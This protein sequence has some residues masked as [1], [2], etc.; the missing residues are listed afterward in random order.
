MVL[1]S[2]AYVLND[3]AVRFAS[4]DGLGVYQVVCL[5]GAMMAA[6]FAGVAMIRG[7]SLTLS[8]IERPVL[9]RVFAE[10]VSTMLFFTALVRMEFA[11]AQAIL[12]ILPLA[13]I[14]A[15]AFV[16][17]EAVSLRRY[18]AVFAGFVGVLIVVRPATDGFTI[19]SIAVLASVASMIVRELA[20]RRVSDA[21]PAL[22]IAFLT[23]VG[24]TVLGGLLATSEGWDSVT[25]RSA[26][27]V[28]LASSLLFFGYL[29]TIQ[30]VRIGDLSVSAPF[31]YSALLGAVVIGYVVFDETP[32]ALMIAGSGL[33]VL[34]GLYSISLD[35]RG[36]SI[37]SD[38]HDRKH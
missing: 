25:N 6:L 38:F 10:M 19:W 23:A 17:G 37:S 16:L 24:N 29:F 14:L 8:H 32:D 35:R 22:S 1:G 5:R 12:Q 9:V 33:I 15:A 30:T 36:L 4:D 2:V 20:T 27:A 7:E 3:A 18:A 28:V 31:R 21:T 26:L 11:N 34:A 13:V